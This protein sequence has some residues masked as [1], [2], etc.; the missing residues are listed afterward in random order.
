MWTRA[1]LALREPPTPLAGVLSLVPA[2]KKFYL[3][4]PQSE[5]Q[6]TRWTPQATR[7]GSSTNGEVSAWIKLL[8]GGRIQPPFFLTE[9]RQA[10]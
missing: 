3:T 8:G 7:G 4:S 1:R 5:L 9:P 2:H 6:G 10:G